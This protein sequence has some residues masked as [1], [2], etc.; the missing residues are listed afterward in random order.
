[1]PLTIT[2]ALEFVNTCSDEAE[3]R[4]LNRYVVTRLKQVREFKAMDIKK[5][6][7]PGMRVSFR[8]GIPQGRGKKRREAILTGVVEDVKQKYVHVRCEES[9]NAGRFS[10]ARLRVPMGDCNICD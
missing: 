6:L 5:D 7:K 4:R 3:L 2:N 8:A 10:G 1:M 9:L